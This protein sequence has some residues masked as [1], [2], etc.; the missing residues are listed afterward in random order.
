MYVC[1]GEDVEGFDEM[2]NEE[3]CETQG[4][5]RYVI[6][7]IMI[8]FCVSLFLIHQTSKAIASIDL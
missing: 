7:P 6:I 5:L 4:K 3:N 1:D 2:W 8:M